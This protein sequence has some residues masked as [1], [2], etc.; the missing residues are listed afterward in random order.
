MSRAD[1]SGSD[2]LPAEESSDSWIRPTV[3][4][5]KQTKYIVYGALLLFVLWSAWELRPSPARV[6]SGAEAAQ[7]LLATMFP[8]DFTPEA[9][10]RIWDGMIESV[11]MSIVAT[12]L[13][14][15][16]SVPIAVMAAENLAPRPV[17]YVGRAIV[18]I[19]RSLHELV[20]AI[21]AVVTVGLGPLAG[22]IALVFATPGFYAKL[23][24]EELEDID[25]GQADAIRA[26]GGSRLQVLV[27]GVA[28]QVVPRMVGLAIYRWDINI[29]AS[30]I[31]GIVG[32]GGI[33]VTLLNSFDR[34]EYDFTL[35]IV[36][37][38][39]A[40]VLAGELASAIIRR[41]LQ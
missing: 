19:S 2:P 27:Y 11:A 34:Y 1:S 39:I 8:P 14:V 25:N 5:N 23:L 26:V 22:V 29:R 9:R 15:A 21:V 24:A 6:L 17:Y 7:G 31:V 13:G 37:S 33:G 32:A 3:F 16:I 35:A 12:I 18:S 20:L 40:V 38:I 10:R 41:R 30:T 4:Y 28:P 36:L